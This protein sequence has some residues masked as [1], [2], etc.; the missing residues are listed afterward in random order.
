MEKECEKEEVQPY[1]KTDYKLIIIIYINFLLFYVSPSIL[2]VT[3]FYFVCHFLM[4][5]VSLSYVLCVTFFYYVCHSLLFCVSLSSIL[6][7]TFFYFV[8]HFLLFCVSLSS[9]L[10]VTF[11]WAVCHFPL[12]CVSPSSILCVTFF[13][14]VCHF[15][16][17]CVSLSS[18]LCVTFLYPVCHFPLV[19]SPSLVSRS[20]TGEAWQEI[21]MSCTPGPETFCSPES[22]DK[23]KLCGSNFAFPYFISFY[24]LCSFLVR[25]N[26]SIYYFLYLNL[27]I[28]IV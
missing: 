19:Y 12:F 1:R 5:C 16:L 8:C 6:C 20:A 23:G 2:C 17:F 15:L 21:M 7:V 22:D 18:G 14:F 25:G 28:K 13:Y 4:F 11:F 9:I 3:F 24:I 10:C 27:K 26:H